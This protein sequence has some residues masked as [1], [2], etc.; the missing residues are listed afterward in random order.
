MCRI[1]FYTYMYKG[2]ADTQLMKLHYCHMQLCVGH[3]KG[4]TFN[5]YSLLFQP[6]S[7]AYSTVL[8]HFL[9]PF[10]N[11]FFQTFF[12]QLNHFSKCPSDECPSYDGSF[13]GQVLRCKCPSDECPSEY[14]VN[15][16]LMFFQPCFKVLRPLWAASFVGW[17]LW[18]LCIKCPSDGCRFVGW[19]LCRMGRS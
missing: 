19:V 8:Q 15:H 14:S 17:V 4:K 9:Q 10:L 3:V 13:V 7:H 2:Q 16:L 6:F 5:G 1:F 12:N 18:V 11:S